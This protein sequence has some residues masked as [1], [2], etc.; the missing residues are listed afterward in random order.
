MEMKI[1]RVLMHVAT[2]LPYAHAE[3]RRGKRKVSTDSLLVDCSEVGGGR[4]KWGEE[5]FVDQ[6]RQVGW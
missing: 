4:W 1:V 6:R 3:S 2:G 5:T